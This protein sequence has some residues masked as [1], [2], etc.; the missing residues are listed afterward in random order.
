MNP[1]GDG[2]S[3]TS[4]RLPWPTKHRA[5]PRL[6]KARCSLMAVRRSGWSAAARHKPL[7]EPY[8]LSHTI[9]VG[10]VAADAG[11]LRGV[12][13]MRASRRWRIAG[14]ATAIL[15]LGAFVVVVQRVAILSWMG[16]LLVVE[17]PLL[18]ADAI[19]PL[20]GGGL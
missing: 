18:H 15:V 5:V 1:Y 6:K 10:R 16:S 14:I 17:D 9:A 8:H 3:P 7:W 13:Q 11:T 12:N 2:P 19:V 4:P 20:A